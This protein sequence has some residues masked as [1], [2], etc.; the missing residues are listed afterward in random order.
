MG[1]KAKQVRDLL[2]I[3]PFSPEFQRADII[4][5]NPMVWIIEVDGIAMDA[6]HLPLEIRTEAYRRGDY[7]IRSGH[8]LNCASR[9]RL[10]SRGCRGRLRS[11]GQT[12]VVQYLEL[13]RRRQVAGL[14]GR[15]L[16]AQGQG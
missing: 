15:R 1:G 14:P 10:P 12:H 7:P 4:E 8:T 6:R 9:P 5:Q 2:R 11:D 13:V 16:Y 3:S